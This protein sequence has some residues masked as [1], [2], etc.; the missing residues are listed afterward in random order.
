MI[1]QGDH[2]AGFVGVEPIQKGNFAL[3]MIAPV[4]AQGRIRLR[5]GF[6]VDEL[7]GDGAAFRVGGRPDLAVTARAG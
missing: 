7:E 1:E 2:M 6:G 4:T 3:Q 5:H